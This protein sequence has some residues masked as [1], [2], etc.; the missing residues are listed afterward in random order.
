[1]TAAASG[2]GGRFDL[3]FARDLT[4]VPLPGRRYART[5]SFEEAG[6]LL[7]PATL[8]LYNS[9]RGFVPQRL[10]PKPKPPNVLKPTPYQLTLPRRW[11]TNPTEQNLHVTNDLIHPPYLTAVT[12]I[13]PVT[14]PRTIITQL[15]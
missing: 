10:F 15:P 3:L 6:G 5:R 14:H 12:T 13:C 8:Y 11:G 9:P 7:T 4:T 2:A 1:M